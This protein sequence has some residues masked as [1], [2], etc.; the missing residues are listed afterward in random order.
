MGTEAATSFISLLS[1]FLNAF[2]NITAIVASL[3]IILI[4]ALYFLI[5]SYYPCLTVDKLNNMMLDLKKTVEDC[6]A[7]AVHL[8]VPENGSVTY[9]KI[10]QKYSRIRMQNNVLRFTF[11]I[12][13]LGARV[14]IIKAVV[15]C[16]QDARALNASLQPVSRIASNENVCSNTTWRLSISHPRLPLETARAVQE[17]NHRELTESQFPANTGLREKMIPLIHGSLDRLPQT[18]P[19]A[20]KVL[21]SSRSSSSRISRAMPA[22]LD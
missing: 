3:V 15:E 9:I 16:Y 7:T 2:S 18:Q 6:R 22:F 14:K 12:A 5:S 11:S 21:E 13:Y 19:Q 10:E 20:L 8:S 1:S 4:V 17:H